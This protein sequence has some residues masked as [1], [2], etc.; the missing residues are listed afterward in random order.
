MKY[1]RLCGVEKLVTPYLEAMTARSGPNSSMRNRM[2]SSI[3]CGAER[4]CGMKDG[5]IKTEGCEEWDKTGQH[6]LRIQ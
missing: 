4:L 2:M 6:I 3:H 5:F 1:A